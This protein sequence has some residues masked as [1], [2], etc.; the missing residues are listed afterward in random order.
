M[1]MGRVL[2]KRRPAWVES[3]SLSAGVS[4]SHFKKARD[5]NWSRRL[6]YITLEEPNLN[7]LERAL[8]A[9]NVA[10][11]WIGSDP[12]NRVLK[13]KDPAENVIQVTAAVAPPSVSSSEAIA[14]S[15]HL[16]HVGLAVARLRAETTMAF[17]RDTLGWP[18]VFRM[19]G[20]DGR[21]ALAKFRLPG[22]RNEVIELIF[23]DPPL[24]KWAAGAFD[25]VNLEVV[26]IDDAYRALRLGGIATQERH[27]PTVNA[28]HLWAI[29]L[30]DPE[31]TR[32][33]V[34]VLTPTTAAIGT[35]LDSRQATGQWRFRRSFHA[36]LELAAS[37]HLLCRR[38]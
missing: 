13:L 30:I 5:S 38:C 37:L 15:T 34:Q 19:A 25:H 1:A 22:Q 12:L 21:L 9:R 29:N 24:N 23:F 8:R 26:N 4:G 18:E 27:R 14:F 16:Q 10:T 11:E 7:D 28:E 3:D 33:E 20:P 6:Q 32:I 35:V 17:Y 2:P 31:L 36:E